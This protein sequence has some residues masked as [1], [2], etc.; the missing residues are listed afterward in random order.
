MSLRPPKLARRILR[1]RLPDQIRLF[2]LGD[3]EERFAALAARSPLRA[4]IWY[5]RQTFAAVFTRLP[6]IAGVVE[7]ARVAG[8]R[9]DLRT[10]LRS[11]RRHPV[12]GGAAVVTLGLGIGVVGTAFSILWGTVLVGLPFEDADRLVHFE[13]SNR[14]LNQS[15]LAVTPHDYLAWRE[16]QRSFEDLGAYVEAAVTLPSL[17]GPPE[18]LVGVRISASS[19]PLLRIQP[20]M[21]RTFSA[22]DEEPGAPP[23]VLV[24]HRVWTSRFG[25]DPEIVGTEVR[26]GGQPTTV[27]GVM[28]AGFGFPIAE[29][30]WLPLRIDLRS[31][32]RGS[33]RLDVF[34]RLRAGVQLETA[35]REFDRIASGLADAY[36]ETNAGIRPELRTFQEEY[37]GPE[38]TQTV[39]RLLAGSVLVLLICCANVANLLLVRSAERARS[40]AVRISLGATRFDI[41]RQLL[42]E[43]LALAVVG[44][45]IGV[46][47]AA[48]GVAWF[49][50]AGTQAG[51]FSLPHGSESL[52]WWEVSLNLPTL[53][54]IIS[55][56]GL[57]AL[58]AGIAPA[59]RGARAAMGL[60]ST[61]GT[62]AASRR[63]TSALVV[64]QITLTAGLVVA[65]GFVTRS[66]IHV[67]QARTEVDGDGV[68][69]ARVGL[70]SSGGDGAGTVYPDHA[71]HLAFTRDLIRR[72][73]ADP[74]VATAGFATSF[75]LERPRTVSVRVSEGSDAL[76]PVLDVGVVTVSPGYFDA[77]QVA[78]VSGRLLDDRD[79]P[80]GQAVALVNESFAAR[81]L[82]DR[83]PVGARIRL[84]P[85]SGTDDADR[86]DPAEPWL[87]VVGVVPD[88]WQ[89]PREPAR[90]AGLYVP[91]SQSAAGDPTA[92]LGRW[93]LQFLT[94]F[95]RS[96]GGLDPPASAV[97]D[98]LHDVDPSLPITWMRSMEETIRQRLGRY[99]VWGRFY[100]A[101][102]GVGLL[103]A[104][105]GVY[106]VLSFWVT[107]RTP[108]IGVRR[109]LG[110]SPGTV[111]RQVLRRACT[112]VG[113]G[114][115]MGLVLGAVL[116]RGLT[117]VLYGVE[118]FDPWVYGSVVILMVSVGV[119]AGWQPAR[120]AARIHPLQAIRQE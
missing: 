17:S 43:A 78:P 40:L 104:T 83:D 67:S 112:H 84:E 2:L 45:S 41:V 92:R 29:E 119:L 42:V 31:F 93:G 7:G 61:R 50:R 60:W 110:A 95:A 97:R 49:N 103:L 4:Q 109:A 76:E 88:L 57:T 56:T 20:A 35:V 106:G 52:F 24:S 39:M 53:A 113:L 10:A 74:T 6:G 38:F 87:L 33:G 77:F 102:A 26:M 58:L 64:V 105:I 98:A 11:L 101:F 62:A 21:G 89:S 69:I 65:A 14:A 18:R 111:Q 47:I 68:I 96:R 108:E 27:I 55:F 12:Q 86:T 117:Q 90:R 37:V 30:V 75:P 8:F 116:I 32:E 82:S 23:V 13:R 70:P 72:L 99:G 9:R 118:P 115:G 19:F 114:L 107:L 36:P 5:W 51:V 91:L 54:A 79:G 1:A 28:P 25:S 81:Y 63:G 73:E 71:S 48:F 3:L 120:R 16:V 100:L 46:A 66:M 15:S 85:S 80:G 94:V 22:T 44:A 34:G 59:A